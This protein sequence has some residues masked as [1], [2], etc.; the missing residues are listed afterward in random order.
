MKASHV[1][2]LEKAVAEAER[3]K[4]QAEAEKE[5][6]KLDYEFKLMQQRQEAERERYKAEKERD[7]LLAELERFRQDDTVNRTVQDIKAGLK[8]DSTLQDAIRLERIAKAKTVEVQQILAPFIAKGYYQPG[9]YK[10]AFES[11]PISLSKLNAFGALEP[12]VKGLDKLIEVA[13][14]KTD[15]E[16]PRWPYSKFLTRLRPEEI[17]RIKQ[18]QAYLIELGDVMVELGMLAP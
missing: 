10:P 12:S 2:M 13:T 4:L 7:D 16:R 9:L 3:I 6:Q 14:K 1:A 11:Q 5:S 18:A 15:K 8:R 17:T